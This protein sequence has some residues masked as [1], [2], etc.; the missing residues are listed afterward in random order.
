MNGIKKMD[1][2]ELALR[3]V[4]WKLYKKGSEILIT[5]DSSSE[6]KELFNNDSK[7]IGF[8]YFPSAPFVVIENNEFKPSTITVS[9]SAFYNSN[10]YNNPDSVF[11]FGITNSDFGMTITVS[12]TSD[13]DPMSFIHERKISEIIF[14]G[15]V[16]NMDTYEGYLGE[17]LDNADRITNILIKLSAMLS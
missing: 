1:D 13:G 7:S 17:N 11:I 16:L 15:D 2:F 14:N 3:L 9:Y 6:I 10:Q 12:L 4:I 8:R 5:D